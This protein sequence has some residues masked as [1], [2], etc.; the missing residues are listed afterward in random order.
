MYSEGSYEPSRFMK[1]FIRSAYVVFDSFSPLDGILSLYP[2]YSCIKRVK[3]I[4]FMFIMDIPASSRLDTL[5]FFAEHILFKY[6][7]ASFGTTIASAMPS[8]K[9]LPLEKRSVDFVASSHR[10][11]N[12][13]VSSSRPQ[14]HNGT[15]MLPESV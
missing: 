8:T 13:L 10:F 3:Y 5:H 7:W 1:I 14:S 15:I 6:I 12:F 11:I 2:L 4:P 9:I